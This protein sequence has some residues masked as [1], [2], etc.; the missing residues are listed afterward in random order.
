MNGANDRTPRRSEPAILTDI[1][2]PEDT[3]PYGTMF[4]GRAYAMMDKAAFLAANRFAHTLAV[5]ASSE[6]VDFTVPIRAGVI[7]EAAARV[8]HT[9][10]TSMVVRVDLSARDP[11]S[12]LVERATVG[13]FTMVA[14]DET[15]RPIPVPELL[16]E[17][18]AEWRHAEQIRAAAKARRDRRAELA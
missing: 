18:E 7:L 15:G 9:G 16:V 10:R 2:F 12:T 13:Y 4:G 6:S 5:T 14:V 3:N 11:L 8:I 1:V 17:D